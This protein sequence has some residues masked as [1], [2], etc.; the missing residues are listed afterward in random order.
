MRFRSLRQRWWLRKPTTRARAAF[1]DKALPKHS[2]GA[3]IGVHKGR[4][5]YVLL[6]AAQ[7]Q[8]L[9]LIDPWWELGTKEWAWAKGNKSIIDAVVGILRDCED[10]LVSGQVELNVGDDLELLPSFPDDYFDWVYLDSTHGYEQTRA[11]LEILKRKVKDSGVIAGD[12]WH[13]E[14]EHRHH[15]VFRAVTEFVE[16]EPYEITHLDERYGQWCLERTRE[17]REAQ[18]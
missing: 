7:P 16:K 6:A 10:E 8:K 12:D 18:E 4:F 11:E 2:V 1:A 14:P 5:T 15:G 9:H 3:E 13:S 17:T